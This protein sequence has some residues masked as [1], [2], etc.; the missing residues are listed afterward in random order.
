MPGGP[1][2]GFQDGVD[3]FQPFG[4]APFRLADAA[5]D[6]YQLS[7]TAYRTLILVKAMSNIIATT[8]PALN[9]L[10]QYLFAGR[11]RAYVNDLGNMQMRYTFEFALEP[12][13]YAILTQSGALPHPAGVE[14]F[15]FTAALP[16]FGFSEAGTESAAP[17]GEG[18]FYT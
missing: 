10:L 15:I 9:A 2:F 8:S 18:I 11:G 16:L 13:E 6:T 12:F 7:D 17:F 5:T 14:T 4:Q 1:Y 3:D